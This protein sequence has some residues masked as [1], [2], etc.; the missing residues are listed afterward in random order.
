LPFG[1][2]HNWWKFVGKSW[3]ISLHVQ[4]RSRR[5]KICSVTDKT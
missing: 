3:L 1:F 2:I 5:L 4:F